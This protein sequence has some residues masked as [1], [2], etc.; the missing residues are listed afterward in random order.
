M[1]R[2]G[3]EKLDVEQAGETLEA[4]RRQRAE[5]EAEAE[6]EIE[7]VMQAFDPA[8]FALSTVR[9][10]PRRSDLSIERIG[11]AWV[12]RAGGAGVA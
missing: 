1:A 10:A 4:I 11:L 3:K 12:P 8:G 5:M 2:T 6:R 9:I 7:R